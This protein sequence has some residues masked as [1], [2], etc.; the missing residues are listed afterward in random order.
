MN[1]PKSAKSAADPYEPLARALAFADQAQRLIHRGTRRS[2]I[3]LLKNHGASKVLDLCCGTGALSTRL[4]K[5]GFHV[6]GVDSSRTMLRRAQRKHRAVGFLLLDAT[7]LPFDG[8]FDAAIIG[9]ALHE[10]APDVRET[11]WASMKKAVRAGGLLV[12]MDFTVP[13]R[14]D[15]FARFV[16]NVIRRDERAFLK[17]HSDHYRNYCEFM[18]GGGL[19]R[20]LTD[21]GEKIVQERYHL[22]GNVGV[23]VVEAR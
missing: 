12:A 15:V 18:E 22:A 9:Q 13:T 3:T 14:R 21:H 4:T 8:E 16:R 6:V 17:I 20:W 23:I 10:M 1:Q 2:I 19:R 5:A 11:V 7:D